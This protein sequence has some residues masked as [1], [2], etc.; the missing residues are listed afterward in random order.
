MRRSIVLLAALCLLP[1][2]IPTMAQNRPVTPRKDWRAATPAELEAVLPVRAPVEKEHIE[3]EMSTA[4]GVIDSHGNAIAAVVLITAGYSAGGKYSHYLLAQAPV[5]IGD[6][7]LPPGKYV[8][9]WARTDDGLLVHF[10]EAETGADRGTVTARP[11]VQ[12]LPV[13][14]IKIWPPNDHGIIQIGRFMVP[15]SPEA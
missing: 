9:G 11:L 5:H 15:Y 14:S 6:L 3:T 12:Q 2:P 8:L 10:Y 4:T 7:S 1:A 13:V